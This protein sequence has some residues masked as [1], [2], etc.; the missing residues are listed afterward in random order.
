MSFHLMVPLHEAI[1]SVAQ[2]N[3]TTCVVL[4]GNGRG[5]CSGADTSPDSGMPP[6]VEGLQRLAGAR[7]K[8]S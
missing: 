3:D 1:E 7:S 4:T 8:P 5:F 2:D 6:N